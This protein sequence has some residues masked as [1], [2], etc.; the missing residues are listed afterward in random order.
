MVKPL[1]M[2][3]KNYEKQLVLLLNHYENVLENYIIV[4][5]SDPNKRETPCMTKSAICMVF[6]FVWRPDYEV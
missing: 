4:K 6:L 1:R 5:S 3:S 2:S